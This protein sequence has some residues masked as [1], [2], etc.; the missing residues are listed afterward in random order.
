MK[1]PQRKQWLERDVDERGERF[2]NPGRHG[3]E[4]WAYGMSPGW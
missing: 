2:E 4:S 3:N 1:D